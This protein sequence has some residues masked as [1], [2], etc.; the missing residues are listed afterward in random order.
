MSLDQSFTETA[1]PGQPLHLFLKKGHPRFVAE[2]VRLLRPLLDALDAFHRAGK[3]HGAVMPSR[4]RVA[5]TGEF[6]LAHFLDHA[7]RPDPG[8]AFVYYADG[9]GESPDE[10]RTRDVQAMAAVLHLIVTDQAPARP[11]RRAQQLAEHPAAKDWP[12]EFIGRLDQLLDGDGPGESPGL[13]EISAALGADSASP[14]AADPAAGAPDTAATEAP[15]EPA[16]EPEPEPTPEPEPEPAI[17]LPAIRLP[18]AMV[19]RGYCADLLSLLGEE[20]PPAE[21]IEPLADLPAGLTLDA[22]Q[23]GGTPRAA[24]DFELRLR[25]HPASPEAGR[26]AFIDLAAVLT[27]NPDPRSLWKN[28]PSD[29]AGPFAKPD[30]AWEILAD[31]PLAVVGASLRGR[32]HAHVGG[33]RDDDL[34]LAWFPRDG[35]YSLTVADGA[36]SSKF[37]R[38]GSKVACETVKG[39]LGTYFTDGQDNPLTRLVEAHALAPDDATATAAVR[40]ELY[41]LFGSAALVARKA[42]DDEAAAC[43]ATARDFHT[44]LITALLHPLADGRW[45]VAAFSVGDGAA[46]LVAGGDTC[47]LTTPDGGE[48]AGQT[49]FHTMREALATGEAIMARIKTAIVPSFDALLL[50]TDGISDPRFSSDAALADPA[51]WDALWQEIRGTMAGSDSREAAA[52][53]LLD[54]MGF[55]SPGHHDDR[56]LVLAT[57]PALFSPP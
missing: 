12:A 9:P 17:R 37:S 54:W 1:V 2:P 47:L 42:I 28:T 19:A 16:P 31:G 23:L 14:A 53:A 40:A 30:S 4:L 22:G 10:R 18:N 48:F 49:V 13:A 46:A 43:Q 44:T 32:S 34:A 55:H 35:W 27:I 20:L 29:P 21:C 25:W 8:E 15:A 57:S 24:G 36:G 26:P 3:S 51:A 38:Q 11:G 6:D 33:Y 41:Q 56:T 7:G 50:V 5:P 45:F 39:H 52:A